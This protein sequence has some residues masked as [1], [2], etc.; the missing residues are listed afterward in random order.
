[1]K[2]IN[3][4]LIMGIILFLLIPIFGFSENKYEERDLLMG[5]LEET[6]ATFSEGDISLGGT[7]LDR[8]IGYEEIVDIGYTIRDELDIQY[9][10]LENDNLNTEME[11]DYYWEEIVEEE[12]FIQL[13]MQGLDRYNNLVTI[14]LSSYKDIDQGPSETYLFINLINRK[15]FVE[16][17]DIIEK[18]EKIFDEYEKPVNITTCVMGTYDGQIDLK[19]NEKKILGVIKTIKGSIVEEYKEDGVLSFSLFTP[20]I[21]EHVFTGNNKMNLNIAIRFNEYEGKTYIWIGTPI[22]TIGY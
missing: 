14:T 16:I 7:I 13:T 11:D 19:E 15:Q 22:I 2:K 5:V 10:E 8:F 21:E 1:M 6:G 9:T 3:K 18:V 17:N 20:Y 12:G 4:Y